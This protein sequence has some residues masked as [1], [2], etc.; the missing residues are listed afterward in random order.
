MVGLLYVAISLL[1]AGA[2]AAWLV[3]DLFY[4]TGDNLDHL[5]VKRYSV[6]VWEPGRERA[7]TEQARDAGR[8]RS[9]RVL[10]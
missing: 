6:R 1:M 3:F 10:V 4:S 7:R 5:M 8:D 2:A 9:A